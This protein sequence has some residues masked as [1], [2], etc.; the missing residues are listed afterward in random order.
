M[1]GLCKH[2]YHHLFYIIINHY[3]CYNPIKRSD[4]ECGE[5][6]SMAAEYGR[7]RRLLRIQRRESFWSAHREN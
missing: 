4:R 1:K 3:L 2:V 6:S 7:S 5:F